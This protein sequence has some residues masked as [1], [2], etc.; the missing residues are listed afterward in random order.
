[1]GRTQ[2]V[3]WFSRFKR[4]RTPV[5]GDDSTEVVPPQAAQTK[6]WRK[7]EKIINEERRSTISEITGMT[8][9]CGGST[10][11]WSLGCSPTNRSSTNSWPL[12]RGCGP[13]PSTLDWCPL[14]IPS[15]FPQL[16]RRY[17]DV[18]RIQVQ[19]LSYRQFQNVCTSCA[20]SGRNATP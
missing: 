9:T 3:D 8:S 10:G 18:P 15:R 5:E 7:F 12:K 2:T 20:S 16:K 4:E 17:K 19:S 6:L 11:G 13:P 1:M 14:S